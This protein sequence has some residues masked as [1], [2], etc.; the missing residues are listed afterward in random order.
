MNSE[1]T[2]EFIHCGLRARAF[3]VRMFKNE[4]PQTKADYACVC[5]TRFLQKIRS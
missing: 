1:G 5:A 2:M 4:K 3:A